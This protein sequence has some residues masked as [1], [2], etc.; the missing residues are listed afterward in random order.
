MGDKESLGY[1][2]ANVQSR[3]MI[4]KAIINSDLDG[5]LSGLLL[6]HFCGTEIVGF[7]D[8]G[9]FVWKKEGIAWEECTFI[10]M[11]VV[12][13]N[14]VTYCNH[15]IAVDEQHANTLF[16][17]TCKNNPN[18]DMQTRTFIGSYN[19]KF[20]L[21]T[22]FYLVAILDNRGTGVYSE[23]GLLLGRVVEGFRCIDVILR[24]DDVAN[25]TLNTYRDNALDWWARMIEH[26]DVR[27]PS[28]CLHTVKGYLDKIHAGEISFDMGRFKDRFFRYVK[29][30][31]Q[32]ET[33]DGGYKGLNFADT[34]LHAH[35][36]NYIRFLS[37]L[38]GLRCFDLSLTMVVYRGTSCRA[39]LSMDDL[40]DIKNGHFRGKG[41]FSYAF[42]SMPSSPNHFSCTYDLKRY[43]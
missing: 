39:E 23:E 17:N 30:N 27:E 6:H 16:W 5:I 12:P 28:R 19:A 11:F 43:Q 10:D 37:D 4:E 24:A 7:C 42:V 15:M 21:S 41:L 18:V 13:E 8:S 29:M 36:K 38:T 40:E 2:P 25:I 3:Y 20:A 1:T 31:Y 9:S 35:T 26:S 14:T 33:P 34:L 32:C 22:F